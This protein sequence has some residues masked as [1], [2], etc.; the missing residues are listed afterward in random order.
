MDSTTAINILTSSE[1][2]EQRYFILVQQ[3]QEL[4]N[5]SWE[6]KISHI[7]R[8]GNKVTDFLANKVHSS[9]IGYHDFEVSDSGLSFW[10]LYDIL[11][12]SQTRLI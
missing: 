12:I 4:L 2:M 10:I 1:H 11:G 3:F 9:S 8:E 5:K 7:Y 6:V